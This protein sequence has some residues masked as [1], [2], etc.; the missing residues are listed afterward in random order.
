MSASRF[1]STVSLA[2]WHVGVGHWAEIRS[3]GSEVFSCWSAL[4]RLSLSHG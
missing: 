4:S 1:A 3:F 2:A